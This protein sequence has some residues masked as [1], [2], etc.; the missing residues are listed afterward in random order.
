MNQSLR[1]SAVVVALV[2]H[3]EQASQLAF[4]ADLD[5]RLLRA[6][7]AADTSAGA[8][9]SGRSGL[10][11]EDLAALSVED[12]ESSCGLSLIESA[13]NRVNRNRTQDPLGPSSRQPILRRH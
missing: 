3:A 2:D 13:R 12:V 7:Q 6:D 9:R 1:Q 4:N 11:P 8:L 5:G 10:R